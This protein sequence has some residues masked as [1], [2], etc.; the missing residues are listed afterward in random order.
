MAQ[1]EPMGREILYVVE[2]E[3]GAVRVLEQG[4]SAG[5]SAGEQVKIGFL[6]GNSLVF[7]TEPQKLIAGAH[8][9]APV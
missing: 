4:S 8:V 7:E 5:H 1:I 3:M 2:T 9:R 6:P